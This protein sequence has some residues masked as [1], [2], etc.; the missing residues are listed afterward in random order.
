MMLA[1]PREAKESPTAS[2]SFRIMMMV[3]NFVAHRVSEVVELVFSI[4]EASESKTSPPKPLCESY[5]VQWDRRS[6]DPREIERRNNLRVIFADISKTDITNKRLFLICNVS[7]EG[8]FRGKHPEVHLD[9]SSNLSKST[10]RSD[11]SKGPIGQMSSRGSPD[12]FFRKPVGVAAV[13]ITDLFTFKQGKTIADSQGRESEHFLP[14][15]LATADNEPFESVFRKL[16]FDK[17]TPNESKTLWVTLN[18]MLGDLTQPLEASLHHHHHLSIARKIGLPEVIL[19]SDFRNDLY[20]TLL[21]GEFSRMGK[22]ADR[23]V[24]VTVEVCDA[25]G[26]PIPNSITGGVGAAVDETYRSVVF[27]HEPRPKWNE[28]TKVMI[29]VDQVRSVPLS[30]GDLSVAVH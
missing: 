4:Y 30:S 2:N 21:N 13:E 25:R 16:V 3:K 27:Y 20:V 12:G 18:V 28:V 9:T 23:N 17:K 29:P 8:N 14:L 26:A 11:L 5:V 15:L 6:Q 24:E 22:G 7:N 19:P 1:K 10:S